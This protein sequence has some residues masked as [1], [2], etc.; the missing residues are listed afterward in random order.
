[1]YQGTGLLSAPS[2][3]YVSRE[4]RLLK[5]KSETAIIVRLE[6][7]GGKYIGDYLCITPNETRLKIQPN[8]GFMLIVDHQ[9]RIITASL[10][11]LKI[12]NLNNCLKCSE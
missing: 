3:G 2:K 9:E 7:K 5:G 11:V 8:D 4:I 6:E 1:M 10:D 12:S